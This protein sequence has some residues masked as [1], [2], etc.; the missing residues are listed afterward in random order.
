VCVDGVAYAPHRQIDVKQLGV[1]FYAFSWYKVFGPH[2]ALLY[3]SWRAL[4]VMQS[5]GHF[6]HAANTL[7]GK[8]GLAGG[9]YELVQSIPHVVNYLGPERRQVVEEQESA[10]VSKLLDYLERVA[11]VY[12][13]GRAELRNPGTERLSTISFSVPGWSPKALVETLEADATLGLKWGDFYCP[14]LIRD[15]LGCGPEGVVRIS[16]LHY[17]TMEEVDLF[18]AALDKL[19]QQKMPGGSRG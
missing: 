17:N 19:V 5:L 4:P 11:I 18:I 14:R 3:A 16:L 12:G 8:L 2:I 6:F 7:E 1:D 10:L 15:L 9:S 13:N